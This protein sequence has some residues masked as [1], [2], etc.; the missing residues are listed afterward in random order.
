MGFRPIRRFPENDSR[1]GINGGCADSFGA[2]SDP[3]PSTNSNR[4]QPGRNLRVEILIPADLPITQA[5]IEVF[6]ALLDDWEGI[7]SDVLQEPTK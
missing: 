3:V 1:D 6:A 2:A 4:G 7:D 5:E